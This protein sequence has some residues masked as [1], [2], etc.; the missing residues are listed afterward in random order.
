MAPVQTFEPRILLRDAA[1]LAMARVEAVPALAPR[2]GGAEAEG[3]RRAAA[4]LR[5]QRVEAAHVLAPSARRLVT[6]IKLVPFLAPG[7]PFG[8]AWPA[9]PLASPAWFETR[10]LREPDATRGLA[11]YMSPAAGP[12]GPERARSF[13]RVLTELAG[14]NHVRDAVSIAVRPNVVA[15]QE[16]TRPP[17]RGQAFP[18]A[19][20][21]AAAPR[22][23]LLFDWPVG[24]AGARAV[25][26]VEAKLG[27]TVG[28]HQLHPYRVEARRLARASLAVKRC[29]K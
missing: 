22:I 8:P 15:E 21:R 9:H 20:G 19:S 28:D 12:R 25:V 18:A 6:G 23:D 26:V 7:G 3:V 16:V 17:R 14:A 5:F 10:P 13:L 27:A 24:D 29:S 2:W 4:H 1:V 11:A